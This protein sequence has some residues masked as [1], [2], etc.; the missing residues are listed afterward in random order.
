[1]ELV[2]VTRAE[3][4]GRDWKSLEAVVA[5][6]FCEMPRAE[7]GKSWGIIS[8]DICNGIVRGYAASEDRC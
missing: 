6:E 7:L 8:G 1:M 3:E 4:R 5:A 2:H